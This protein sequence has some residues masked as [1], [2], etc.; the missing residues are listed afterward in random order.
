MC[1]AQAFV[2]LA[3][4]GATAASAGTEVAP[5]AALYEGRKTVALFPATAQARLALLRS[6]PYYR[7]T[8]D[9]TLRWTL[10]ERRFHECSVLRIDGGRLWPVEYRHVDAGDAELN[11]HTRFDWTRGQAST[12]RGTQ[13]VRQSVDIAWPTWDPM[14]FQVALMAAAPLRPAAS[15]EP[16]QVV[17]RGRLRA[18]SVEFTGTLAGV[19][20]PLHRIASRKGDDELLLWLLPQ[21]GWQPQRMVIDGVTIE[22]SGTAAPLPALALEAGQAPS[23]GSGPAP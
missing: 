13:A 20:P 22:R 1:G 7:Y 10:M 16:H 14:S 8:M 11:L 5:F 2:V 15:V 4:A 12:L 3:L 21:Q 18:H 6:G 19:Q 9:T 23:C 17:E